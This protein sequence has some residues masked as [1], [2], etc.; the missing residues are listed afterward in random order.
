MARSATGAAFGGAGT[1]AA[2]GLLAGTT[3]FGTDIFTRLVKDEEGAGNGYI[4]MENYWDANGKPVGK[5]S[6][7]LSVIPVVNDE[8]TTNTFIITGSDIIRYE[9][10]QTGDTYGVMRIA[11]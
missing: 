5:S 11:R 8:F 10:P 4:I 7:L 2:M 9:D 3:Q 1:G 6:A